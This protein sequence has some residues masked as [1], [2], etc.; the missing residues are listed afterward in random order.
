MK[1]IL[2]SFSLLLLVGCSSFAKPTIHI[3]TDGVN[4]ARLTNLKAK[5][6]ANGYTVV[7]GNQDF[8]HFLFTPLIVVP[9]NSK[10]ASQEIQQQ[11]T[12]TFGSIPIIKR[13]NFKNHKYS[14][15]H[16]GVYLRGSNDT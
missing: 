11:I 9:K 10:F 8:S 12:D 4:E 13:G 5:L 16:I 7:Y 2:L 14:D 15:G 3:H 1:T 6:E